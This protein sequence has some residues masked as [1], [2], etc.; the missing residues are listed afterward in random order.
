M[1]EVGDLVVETGSA[2]ATANTYV[3][4]ADANAYHDKRLY[5]KTWEDAD[6]EKKARALVWA[7]RLIDQHCDWKGEPTTTGQALRWPRSGVATR[8]MDAL[9]ASDTVPQW[10]KDGTAEMARHLLEKN[11]PDESENQAVT[12]SSTARGSK[13]VQRDNRYKAVIPPSVRAMFSPYIKD[14]I[15]R[16]ERV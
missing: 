4:L 9:I 16:V 10:L 1:F 2:S 7:T 14:T 6:D 5:T 13:G 15:F 8:D 3:S 12:S 11:R